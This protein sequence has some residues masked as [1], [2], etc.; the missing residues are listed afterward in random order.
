[1]R[2]R[3][4]LTVDSA[5]FLDLGGTRILRDLADPIPAAVAGT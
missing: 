4:G 1:V 5:A 3:L 2:G